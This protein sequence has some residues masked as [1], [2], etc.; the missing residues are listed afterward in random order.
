MEIKFRQFHKQITYLQN[1][2]DK[3]RKTLTLLKY[4][5]PELF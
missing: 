3:W 5:Y 2:Q 4:Y 1:I